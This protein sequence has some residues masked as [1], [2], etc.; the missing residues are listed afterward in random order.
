VSSRS[1]EPCKLLYPSLLYFTV[2]ATGLFWS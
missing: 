2:R 1:G